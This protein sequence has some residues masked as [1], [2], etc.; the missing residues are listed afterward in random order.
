[1]QQP[2][3]ILVSQQV[4][5]GY[6]AGLEEALGTTVKEDHII[7]TWSMLAENIATAF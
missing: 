2:V 5:G 6:C 4:L 3:K 7:N 1:M